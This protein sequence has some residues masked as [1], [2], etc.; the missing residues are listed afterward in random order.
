MSDQVPDGKTPNV[1]SGGNM[2]VCAL[3]MHLGNFSFSGG[4]TVNNLHLFDVD[5]GDPIGY[6]RISMTSPGD[7]N[8]TGMIIGYNLVSNHG[9]LL[10]INN[11]GPGNLVLI[12]NSGLSV[13]RAR[14][15]FGGGGDQT[16]SANKTTVI[17]YD[18][19]SLKWINAG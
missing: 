19:I 6:L 2:T 16:I 10:V 15:D 17:V 5:D 7:V 4:S 12:E 18:P 14:F 8:L 9:Q 13:A 11:V 1:T 3:T